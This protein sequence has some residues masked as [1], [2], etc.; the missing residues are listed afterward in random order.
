MKPQ[1]DSSTYRFE[2]YVSKELFL[3]YYNQIKMISKIN[4]RNMLN[5]GVGGKVIEKLIPDSIECFGLDH[6]IELKPT[7]QASIEELPFKDNTFD[8]VTCFEVLEHLPFE[9]FEFLL[10]ELSRVSRKDVLLS[11]PFANNKFKLSIFLPVIHDI[12]FQYLLPKFYRKHEFDGIHYWEIGKRNFPMI[13]I[14]D[15]ISGV[16]DIEERYTL[17]DFTYHTFFYLHK[18]K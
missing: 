1:V 7:V 11:L 16:F 17:N 13:K 14:T 18:R 9:K 3:S 12:T 8:L 5:I 2:D 4:P 10:K 15:I 6:D